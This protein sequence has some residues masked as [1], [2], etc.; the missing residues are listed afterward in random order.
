MS[1]RQAGGPESQYSALLMAYGG[2]DSLADVP[3][4]LL[5]VR[6]GRPTPPE[7]VEEIKHRYE[8]I[9]GRSPLLDI[10]RAQAR[11][12]E[13]RLRVNGENVRAYVG[14]RHWQPRIAE[15]VRQIARDGA[16]RLVAVAMAT[17]STS[18]TG[19]CPTRP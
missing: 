11:A 17:S 2:P 15:A 7:L 10:T 12:L 6:G 9:G 1:M 13:D 16:R 5:D 8:A 18:G 19:S 4:Y 3:A 14:M